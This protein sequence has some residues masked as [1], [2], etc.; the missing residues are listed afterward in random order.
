MNVLPNDNLLDQILLDFKKY[1]YNISNLNENYS[2]YNLK[3]PLLLSEKD[4]EDYKGTN[5]E[6]VDLDP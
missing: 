3:N 4:I 5:D 1:G 6:I 2:K